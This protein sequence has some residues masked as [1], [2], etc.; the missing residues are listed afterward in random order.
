MREYSHP[1]PEPL[2][3]DGG[4]SDDVVRRAADAPD[5]VAFSRR[6]PDGWEPVTT[7]EFLADVRAV[8]KGLVAAG[9]RKGDRL[10]L[11]ARTRYEWTVVDYAAWYVGVVTVPV[12]ETSADEQL[13]W[14]L[15]DS[16]ARFCV[17]EHEGHLA[18]VASLRAP[19]G[20]LPALEATW[21]I[22][23]DGSPL[24][25]LAAAGAEVADEE[26]ETR[27]GAV[28]PDD[29]ATLVY[30]SGTT[31]RPRGCVITHRNLMFE[32]DV[33]LGEID[34]V[35][36]AADAN[37][38]LFLPLAHVFARIVQVG[39]VRA[40]VRLAH[41]PDV[42]RLLED[43]AELRPTFVLG[44]PRV[45]EKLFTVASQQAAASGRGAMFDRAVDT[46]MAYSRASEA[47]RP[48]PVL[49]ARHAFFERTVYSRLREALGG[50]CSAM[51]S[52]GA[53]LGERLGHFYRGAGMPV[54]E[55]YGLTETTGAVTL[56]TP[57]AARVGT[58]G[59]PLPGTAV[60]VSDDGE[61]LVKGGQVGEG[62][63][64]DG[65]PTPATTPDG[66]F[67]TGDL[68]E[69]D[70]EGFV[71]VTGRRTE[72]L[73]TSGGKNVSPTLLEDRL[74]A[75]ALVSQCMV[76]GDGRPYVAALVTLDRDAALE[77]ARQRGRR[78]DLRELTSDADLR[79]ELQAAVDEVNEAVSI[80]ESIRRF[81]VLASDWSEES[82]HL[83][84][85]LKLR[86]HAIMRDF[87][88]DVQTLYDS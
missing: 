27:R 29:V 61:L 67:A 1:L 4:L 32:L 58:V 41:S 25:D 49:R 2:A 23:G 72:V 85:S 3:L 65:A 78:G 53:P 60:R 46:A 5:H 52:G 59:R 18:R 63:W 86:R 28:E 24:A 48:G 44:V 14:I 80:A 73:V 17:V 13:A 77:W 62:Y 31:G 68:G 35:L 30:T 26:L 74:R 51:I 75:H 6:G 57:D 7:R 47:G 79:A 33:V 54:L 66:W 40:G 76:V 10:A 56:N 43:L 38:V 84:P 45:F 82:G 9:A 39:A 37:T 34:E 71:R 88:A 20:A 16:G 55:G 19:A 70:D 69:I 15:A 11:L 81:T 87:R 42:S 21:R 64:H 83:T 36:R 8:A 22:V 12:Y 50:R